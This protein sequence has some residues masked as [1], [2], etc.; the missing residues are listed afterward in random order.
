VW[1]GMTLLGK[2]KTREK[3]GL[4]MTFEGQRNRVRSPG[5]THSHGVGDLL[6]RLNQ[7]SHNYLYS[8]GE[9]SRPYRIGVTLQI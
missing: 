7:Q 5:E 9:F 8:N 2:S 1:A 3:A 6:P 4:H